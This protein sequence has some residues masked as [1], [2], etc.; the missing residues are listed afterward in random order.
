M[1]A[2]RGMPKPKLPMIRRVWISSASVEWITPPSPVL[3]V[4]VACMENTTG[5]AQPAPKARPK[6]SRLPSEA[7]AS[8]TTGMPVRALSRS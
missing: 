1:V 7:A 2:E 8:I 6:A 5:S 4:L 3:K